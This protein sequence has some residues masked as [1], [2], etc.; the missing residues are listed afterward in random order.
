LWLTAISTAFAMTGLWVLTIGLEGWY[1]GAIN[2]AQ[3]AT[4]LVAA[5]L[6]L[7]PPLD[8]IAGLPGYVADVAGLALAAIVLAPRIMKAFAGQVERQAA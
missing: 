2:I 4:V 5:I 7:L 6:I 1:R 8:R 3:R